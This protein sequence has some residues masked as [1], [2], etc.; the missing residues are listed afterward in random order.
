MK[1]E[2]KVLYRYWEG[3][4]SSN[5]DDFETQVTSAI[6]VFGILMDLM[7]VPGPRPEQ[8]MVKSTRGTII[9]SIHNLFYYH[10]MWAKDLL[11]IMLNL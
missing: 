4:D 2:P 11:D 10:I 8:E 5:V 9:Y 1:R 6:D 3:V 7:T